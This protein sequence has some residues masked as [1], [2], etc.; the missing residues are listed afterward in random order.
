M[1]R[2][3]GSWPLRRPK[4]ILRIRDSFTLQNDIPEVKIAFLRV[5]FGVKIAFPRM[6][7]CLSGVWGRS[8][9]ENLTFYALNL[10]TKPHFEVYLNTSKIHIQIERVTEHLFVCIFKGKIF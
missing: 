2:D 6:V 9:Q 8:P 7:V 4:K 1:R 3:R 5:D 10:E